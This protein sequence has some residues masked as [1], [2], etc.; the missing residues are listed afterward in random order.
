[1]DG[2]DPATSFGPEVARRYD[3]T[4]RGDEA[5]TVALL[6][7]L[8]GDG[9]ALEL[10]IG[11]G[12]IA[13]PLAARGVRVDGIELSPDM[14]DRLR[15]KPGGDDIDVTMGDMARTPAPGTY[16]LVYLVFNTIFNLLTQDDQVRCFENA[17]RH[18]AGDGVFVVEAAVPRAWTEQY[19][20]V[21]PE[22]VGKD[23][24]VFDVC[25]Y[26]PVTQLLEENHVE[27]SS[28]GIRFGPLVCRLIW[29]SEMD[30][31]ARL[32]GLRLVERW[33]GWEREPFTARSTRHVS[34]YELGD[35]REG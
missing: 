27:L 24:V 1:M 14:V 33:G 31:M 8:A 18:L 17:A 23:S 29:P 21:N 26:D 6:T 28:A 20:Y 11:T 19:D 25:R 30:L 32:A 22:H 9:R 15:A 2:F 16:S 3:D 7:E 4:P 13:L 35:S 34:V 12:R 5:E 10:A